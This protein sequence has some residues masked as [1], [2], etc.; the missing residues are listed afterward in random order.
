ML[1]QEQVACGRVWLLLRYLDEAGRGWVAPD[2]VRRLLT[3]RASFL[4]LFGERQLRKLLA[5]GEGLFWQ[6]DEGHIG[7]AG[8]A[9][10]AAA[11][12]VEKLA[13]KPV[14]LPRLAATQQLLRA[15][16]ASGA[17]PRASS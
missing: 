15:A 10:V 4:Y 14:A 13:G 16:R 11:V 2:E 1:K 5:Q 8:V 17:R 9:R 6:R 7:L 12:R 3:D